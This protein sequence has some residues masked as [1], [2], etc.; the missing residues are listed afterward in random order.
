MTL[1]STLQIAKNAL[2]ASQAGIQ[3]AAN[4][5]ANADTPG[6][7]REKLVQ[8][9]GPTQRTGRL[10][11]GTGVLVEGVVRQV[12]RFL[13]ERL[14]SAGSDLGNG[15]MQETVYLDLETV[16]GEL[17]DSDLSTALTSFFN[18]L[19]DVLN[20][21]EDFAVRNLAVVSGDSLA[22]QVRYLDSRVSDLRAMAN[23]QIVNAAQDVNTLV[24]E[25]ARLNVQIIE[26]E[27]GGSMV[28]EAVGLRDK[29]DMALEGLAKIINIDVEEQKSGAVN[30]FVGGEYL[31]FDGTT[32]L[33]KVIPQVDR[34][35][36]AAELRLTRSDA[37]LRVSSGELGGLFTARDE[38][39][40]GFL[41]EL[42]TF[43]RALIF[44]FNKIHASGQGLTGYDALVSEHGIPDASKPLDEAG[45]AFTPVHGSLQV[46][47]TNRQTGAR[48][49]HDL[50]IRLDGLDGDTTYEDLVRDLD[51]IDGLAANRTLEGR[52]DLR[53]ESADL[54]FSFANDTSGVLAALGINTLFAGTT[55]ADLRVNQDLLAD[56]GKLA[57]SV[58]GAGA[59]TKNGERLAELLTTPLDNPSDTSLWQ[60]FERWMGETAQASAL[61]KAVAEGYRSFHSALESEHLGLSG[62]SLD[63]EAVNMMAY[64]RTFQAAAK[65]I[66]TISE[67][68]DILVRL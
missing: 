59:D 29:R 9:P 34:G 62:V 28:S 13:Q 11:T 36:A 7:I 42:D 55:A 31:V 58:G 3:V 25:I 2:S 23:D 52:L 26:M 35:G 43:A 56:A 8:T 33:V 60:Q 67:L 38:I 10:V 1:L 40:A 41:D 32:Q 57:F 48:K 64:Q 44:E 65:V 19:N 5:V 66:S 37:Q 63:E 61:S 30:V 51:A 39:L 4:N 53:S 21:P 17:S 24:T 27:L 14:W 49:T 16:I 12:N 22:T 68:L 18:S 6:Y 54:E 45:L 50:F 20:Q 47:V 15:V 46:V